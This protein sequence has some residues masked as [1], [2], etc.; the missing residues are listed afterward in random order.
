VNDSDLASKERELE[1]RAQTQRSGEGWPMQV[2]T[3]EFML[4]GERNWKTG[5]QI[6]KSANLQTPLSILPELSCS[7]YPKNALLV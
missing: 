3:S 5:S 2:T 1:I 6:R 4:L 7:A